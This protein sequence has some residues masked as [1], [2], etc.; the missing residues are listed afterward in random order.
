M[1][2]AETTMVQ[3]KEKAGP[4]DVLQAWQTNLLPLMRWILVG[5]T[6]FF[7]LASC[8][9][10]YLLNQSIQNEPKVDTE[11]ALSLLSLR[12]NPS[13]QEILAATRLKGAVTLEAA[14]IDNQFHQGGVLLMSRVWTTYLGFV[15]GMILA[16]VGAA[17][18]LGKL[19]DE[20]ASELKGEGHGLSASLTS[21][22]PGL[23]LAMLGV[24][25][26]ITSIVIHHSIEVTIR[27]I[28]LTPEFGSSSSQS[29]APDPITIPND[30]PKTVKEPAPKA[31]VIPNKA[32]KP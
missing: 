11:A 22:S 32:E 8:V 23:M 12:P 24:A 29:S 17:F 13:S 27:A 15:T 26:M 28:Y 7:F 21:A 14:N 31:L 6:V 16:L 30:K 4:K 2:S 5:L 3:G 18:V 1:D 25:L 9:Q 10:L 19:H 20:D